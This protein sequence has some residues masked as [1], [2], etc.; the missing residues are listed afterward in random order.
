MNSKEIK[1][2]AIDR[3]HKRTWDKRLGRNKEYYIEE[4]NPT[5]NHHQKTYIEVI[6][7]DI[8]GHPPFPNGSKQFSGHFGNLLFLAGFHFRGHFEGLNEVFSRS[9]FSMIAEG[10]IE[11]PK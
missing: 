9:R 5:F 7:V 10:M 4:F 3:F 8:G 6:Q 2:F 11:P 1:T